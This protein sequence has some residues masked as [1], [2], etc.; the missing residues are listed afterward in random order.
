[1][2]RVSD[3]PF[4]KSIFSAFANQDVLNINDSQGG[5][6]NDSEDM[7]Y[8]GSEDFN[9]QN[10]PNHHHYLDNHHTKK[11]DTNSGE[12]SLSTREDQKLE[13]KDD[14]I[15]YKSDEDANIPSNNVGKNP[16]THQRTNSAT[17]YFENILGDP[18]TGHLRRQIKHDSPEEFFSMLPQNAAQFFPR[19]GYLAG[20]DS[21]RTPAQGDRTY[22]VDHAQSNYEFPVPYQST[23][24]GQLNSLPLHS[25]SKPNDLKLNMKRD[26]T[27]NTS[28]SKP[29]G[30]K[31]SGPPSSKRALHSIVE[32]KYRTNIN[33]RLTE[34]KETV[35]TIRFTYKRISNL[36][37]TEDDH[38]QLNGMEPAK[39]LNKA[40]ILHKATEY[41]RFLEQEN[42][43]LKAQNAQ[44]Q[45]II[46]YSINAPR[47]QQSCSNPHSRDN[48]RK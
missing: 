29:E 26:Y 20:I 2:L 24:S 28:V 34:L 25:T 8:I 4:Q 41:I 13:E 19:G 10:F 32:K 27:R 15:D 44:L 11:I 46:N 30:K 12:S 23:I 22:S 31:K 9:P 47:A 5:N 3:M 35:P 33:D 37:L 16:P 14:W 38:R 17:K 39:K 42:S 48:R 40:T 6:A 1:M 7:M 45:N 43:A 21:D 18:Y 36:P